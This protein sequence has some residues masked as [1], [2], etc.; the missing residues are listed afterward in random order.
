MRPS[1]DHC[2]SFESGIRC[3]LESNNSLTEARD[4][5][6]GRAAAREAGIEENSTKYEYQFAVLMIY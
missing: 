3:Y 5:N 1:T 6:C 4:G 2:W